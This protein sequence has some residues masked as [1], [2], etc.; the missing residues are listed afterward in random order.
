MPGFAN[1]VMYADN[2]RFDGG[3]YPGEMN[4]D[5]QLLIGSTAP[6]NIKVGQLQP[7]TG[8]KIT[9]R[10]GSISVS[11][12]GGGLSWTTKGANDALVSNNGYIANAGA[13]LSFSLPATSSVGDIVALSLDG[14]TS[15]TITQ[16]ANQQIRFGASETTLGAGGSLAST[17]QGDTVY[18]VCVTANL[19]WIVLNSVG[20]ISIA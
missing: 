17:A 5:G 3:D 9:N 12:L 7:G 20:N 8:I 4:A 1:G 11:S 18:M 6:P 10:S 15:W 19:R 16:A 14:A 2:V 13:A